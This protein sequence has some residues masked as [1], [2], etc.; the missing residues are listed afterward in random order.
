MAKMALGLIETRGM[1]PAVE[2]ADVALKAANV[3]LAGSRAT[4]SGLISISLVGDVAAVRAA[5]EAG[6]AAAARLGE[7]VSVEVL[8][9][10]HDEL[11]KLM[12]K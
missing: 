4:G 6:A 7:V 1:V 11:D 10:P 12:P 3:A 8:S 2:A 9:R 5:T